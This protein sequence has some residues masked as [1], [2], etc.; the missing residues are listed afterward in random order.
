M[1]MKEQIINGTL[2]EKVKGKVVPEI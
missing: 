1:R 2:H